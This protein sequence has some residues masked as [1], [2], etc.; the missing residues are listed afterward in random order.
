M[1]RTNEAP[2]KIPILDLNHSA[3][4]HFKGN[5]PTLELQ[6]GR[7][8]F[9]FDPTETFYRLSARYN[10]NEPVPCLDFVNAQRQLKAMMLALK[11]TGG[12]QG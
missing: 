9:C 12:G 1:K 2:A 6:G 4:Q 3:F 7:V 5:S 10:G 11:H 8:V